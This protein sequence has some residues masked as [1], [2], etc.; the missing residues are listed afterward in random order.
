MIAPLLL[1]AVLCVQEEPPS[2]VTATVEPVEG[3]AIGQPVIWRILVD[4][5]ERDGAATWVEAPKFDLEWALDEG[6]RSV[7]GGNFGAEWTLLPLEGGELRTP[8]VVLRFSDGAELI[9][10]PAVIDV[11]HALVDGEDEP[12]D[13]PGFREVEDRRI[14]DPT[15]ALAAL[16]AVLII[17]LTLLGVVAIRRRRAR[18]A[19]AD[20]E[21]LDPVDEIRRLEPSNDPTGSMVRLAPLVRRSVEAR[22]ETSRSSLTDEEWAAWFEAGEGNAELRARA[23]KLVLASTAVRFGGGA[24]TRFAAEDAKREALEIVESPEWS[25][26]EAAQ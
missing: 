18:S 23:A 5:P 25:T 24:P 10:P 22:I 9:V 11:P 16:S 1:A 17:P 7:D 12:R 8:E 4:D 13:L 14:G 3:L 2:G 20:G 19:P 26:A 15:V 6:P 21:P